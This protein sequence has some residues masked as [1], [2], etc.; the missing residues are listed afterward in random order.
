MFTVGLT[1]GIACGKSLV[2]AVLASKP[3]CFVRS[4]DRAARNLMRRRS[5]VT[6]ALVD[7]F[8]AGILRPDG[9]VDRAALG[10]IVFHDA[11]QRA[12]V[13]KLIHPRVLTR[14]KIQMT[15]LRNE[16]RTRIY[17]SESA[18]L[19]EAGLPDLFDRIVVVFCSE[20]EQIR[21]LMSRD[22]I[23]RREALSRIRAQLPQKEKIGR[24]DYLID[25]SGRPEDTLDQSERLYAQLSA[26][27]DMREA[28]RTGISKP[29]QA[30]ES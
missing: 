17:V 4:A 12:W 23:G 13:E 14:M 29:P 18:L 16:G 9:A 6:N 5:P 24:A 30:A 10:R 15:R 25:A 28:L 3:G 22:G 26:E 1:G 20:S 19:Y 8:G 2:A 27:A 11:G 21:R 7:R